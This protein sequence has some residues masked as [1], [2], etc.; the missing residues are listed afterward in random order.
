MDAAASV[1]FIED[2]GSDL[3]KAR[4]RWILYGE[5]P[6]PA[7]VGPFLD[8][9]NTDG[10][11]P[12]RMEPGLPSALNHT[13][14]A[15]LR[16]DELGMLGSPSAKRAFEF[17]C[18]R[19]K[20]DGGWD[21]NPRLTDCETPPWGTPGDTRARVYLTSQ[22]AFWLAAGGYKG[23]PAFQKALD[24]LASHQEKSGRFQGFLHT[25]WIASSAF[26]MAGDPNLKVV[27]KG[28]EALLAVP[29]SEWVDSQIS[30]ALGCLGRA[31]LPRSHPFA[32]KILP[33]LVD[34]R[35]E[36]GAWASEDGEAQRVGAT[37]EALKALKHYGM[38]SG[39]GMGLS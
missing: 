16:M 6:D 10:G 37:L 18:N 31:G 26:L 20:D 3:E 35:A 19:Q 17:T 33:T 39:V 4:L 30:W 21:E 36:D 11:F 24:Y 29:L 12:F 32:E 23:H 28:L 15:L 25:T 38:L 22:S 34:R 8:L 27:E 1:S 14:G 7:V 2:R 5:S 9:Q 13:H